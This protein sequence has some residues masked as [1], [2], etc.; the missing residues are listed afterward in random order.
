MPAPAVNGEP[1]QL[2]TEQKKTTKGFNSLPDDVKPLNKIDLMP[3]TM[4]AHESEHWKQRD[5]SKLKDIAKLEKTTDWSFSTPYKGTVLKLS[6]S[7]ACIQKETQFSPSVL[8]HLSTAA[9]KPFKASLI[10]EG[11]PDIPVEMLG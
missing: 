2:T 7:L 1:P 4:T 5:F 10:T 8:A 9:D 3:I 11:A 6:E